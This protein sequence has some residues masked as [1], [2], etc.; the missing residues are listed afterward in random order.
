MGVADDQRDPTYAAC[1]QPVD[2]LALHDDILGQLDVQ[3]QHFAHAIGKGSS[4]TVTCTA[5]AYLP[6]MVAAP[7][8]GCMVRCIRSLES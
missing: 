8:A 7:L 2:E 6:A 4:A 1:D 3:A 5:R